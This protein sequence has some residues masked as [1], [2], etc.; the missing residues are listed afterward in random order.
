MATVSLEAAMAGGAAIAAVNRKAQS[1]SD[2]RN[3][4][5]IE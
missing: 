1:A 4:G 2:R 3:D 5:L